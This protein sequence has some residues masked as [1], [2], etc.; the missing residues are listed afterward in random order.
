MKQYNFDRQSVTSRSETGKIK[1][2]LPIHTKDNDKL[3][4]ISELMTKGEALSLQFP[5]VKFQ[6]EVNLI[7]ETDYKIIADDLSW[8]GQFLDQGY[9]F[10]YNVANNFVIIGHKT[11]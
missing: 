8:K 3:I 4:Q 7:N 11:P 6:V 1:S 5:D 9:R 2:I 10:F